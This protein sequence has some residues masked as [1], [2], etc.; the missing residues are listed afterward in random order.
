MLLKSPRRFTNRRLVIEYEELLRLF[1]I[2][3]VKYPSERAA[4]R[5]SVITNE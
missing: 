1:L 5:L 3:I 2:P 4:V